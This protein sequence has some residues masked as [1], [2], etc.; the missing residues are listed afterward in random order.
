[1]NRRLSTT[2]LCPMFMLLHD[3]CLAKTGAAA[4]SFSSPAEGLA[5]VEMLTD[6]KR[7]MNLQPGR[8][9]EIMR[10]RLKNGPVVLDVGAGTGDFTFLFSEAV[11]TQGKV[12]AT[13]TD[14]DMLKYL[15]ERIGERRCSNVF[16]VL[17]AK[18]GVDSFYREHAFDLVFMAN[19]YDY[20]F[21]PGDYLR[22]LK[23][24][25][26]KDGRLYILHQRNDGAL[27]E[28][29]LDD[30]KKII[31][32]LAREKADYPFLRE[33]SEGT[34]HFIRTWDKQDVPDHAKE[35]IL[36]SFNAMLSDPSLHD[37]LASY[38]Y[39]QG[40]DAGP[41]KIPR[42]NLRR[43][44]V[45]LVRFLAVFLEENQ[46]LEKG[47]L[48]GEAY[49]KP[50]R[51]LNRILIK[52]ILGQEPVVPAA[53]HG[54]IIFSEKK[55][56]MRTAERAGY[57]LVHEYGFLPKHIFLEFEAPAPQNPGPP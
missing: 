53:S 1:M 6:S 28:D 29:E 57:R 14:P 32:I 34:R 25:L 41:L 7:T 31:M 17:V 21:D 42:S 4:Q 33:L 3:P 8:L 54:T 49:L 37:D 46:I 9:L 40:A 13:E 55:D 10:P 5:K 52:G 19:V 22:Q 35:D 11:G 2:L 20:L 16:P 51:I 39:A 15:E 30:F 47:K 12:F 45:S 24:S 36:S 56:I 50:L 23:S 44:D 27:T 18:R 43:G 38:Y 48:P 26:K